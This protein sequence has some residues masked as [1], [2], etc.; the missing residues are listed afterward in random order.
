MVCISLCQAHSISFSLVN[1]EYVLPWGQHVF[2][3]KIS[4]TTL[5][6][7]EFTFLVF[8]WAAYFCRHNAGATAS[9]A[10]QQFAVKSAWRNGMVLLTVCLVVVFIQ[11]TAGLNAWLT[12]YSYTYLTQRAGHGLLNVIT[13]AVGNA[14]SFAWASRS[15]YSTQVPD[16]PCCIDF[17]N[18]SVVHGRR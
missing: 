16:N 18:I 13:I 6:Q 8:F 2:W 17:D 12:D 10:I 4:T 15:I 5:F 7:A 11:S 9:I 14:G 1:W 3:D